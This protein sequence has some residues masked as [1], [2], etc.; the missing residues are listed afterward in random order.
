M[1][2]SMSSRR[3]RECWRAGRSRSDPRVRKRSTNTAN[4]VSGM[5]LRV[6]PKDGHG[7]QPDNW[8]ATRSVAVL[9]EL[10]LV[11]NALR[12]APLANSHTSIKVSHERGFV[13][14]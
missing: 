9:C 14:S 2:F 1:L 3:L 6:C 8:N 7:P 12:A 10:A 11:D 5:S 13:P 4:N